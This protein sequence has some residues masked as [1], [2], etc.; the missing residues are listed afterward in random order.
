MYV[1]S[2]T[3]NYNLSSPL[4]FLCMG[5]ITLQK[6]KKMKISHIIVVYFKRLLVQYY[7]RLVNSPSKCMNLMFLSQTERIN[8]Y[9]QTIVL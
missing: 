8:Y 5:I 4:S 6:N 9:L 7:I 1:M 3:L 2:K